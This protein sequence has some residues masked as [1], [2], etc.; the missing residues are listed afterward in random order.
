MSH[1]W[2]IYFFPNMRKFDVKVPSFGK[3]ILS[4]YWYVS[5]PQYHSQIL[6]MLG[7]DMS[8][9][10]SQTLQMLGCDMSQYRSQ[11]LQM[12]GCDMSQ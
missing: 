3:K 10:H 9:Y 7:C 4:Q 8:Q 6:E 2:E 5:L 12:L 1:L 11:T